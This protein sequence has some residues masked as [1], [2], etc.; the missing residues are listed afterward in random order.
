VALVLDLRDN[1][2]GATQAAIDVADRFLDSGVIT[3]FVRR[4]TSEEAIVAHPGVATT[5][6]LAVLI[7]ETSASASE[8][9]AAALQD[10][11]RAI[12]IGARSFGKGHGQALIPLADSL[13]G[14]RLTVLEFLTPSHR[15]IERHFAGQDSTTG[16]VWPDSGMTVP[17]R[18]DEFQRWE[19]GLFAL[20]DVMGFSNGQGPSPVPAPDRVLDHAVAVLRAQVTKTPSRR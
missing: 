6:P 19:E 2:G 4:D 18:G 20:D 5:L 11:H 16:G 8:L 13:S 14:V 12:V 1:G 3:R 17:V 7:N 9:V 15:R 10:N